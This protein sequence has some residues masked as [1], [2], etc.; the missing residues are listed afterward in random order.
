MTCKIIHTPSISQKLDSFL[1]A[2][3]GNTSSNCLDNFL[4][5]GGRKNRTQIPIYKKNY[6]GEIKC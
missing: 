4:N 5:S 3:H 6:F 2:K 1:N